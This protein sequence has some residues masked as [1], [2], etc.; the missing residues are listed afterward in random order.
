VR[1]TRSNR[2]TRIG[3]SGRDLDL[4][5]IKCEDEGSIHGQLRS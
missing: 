1:S 2:S 4:L 3:I 5:A